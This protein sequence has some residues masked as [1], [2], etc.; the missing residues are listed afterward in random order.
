M[1]LIKTLSVG[2]LVTTFLAGPWLGWTAEAKEKKASAKTKP[3]PLETCLVSGEKL[4]GSMG[5]P[6][7]FAYEGREIKMCCKDCKKDFDKTPAKFVAKF[8][9]AWKKVKAYP[10]ET[11][12]VSGDK[13]GDKDYAFV[14]KNQEIRL[15][16]KDCLKEFNKD[17][18]KYLK[19]IEV[20]AAKA[21]K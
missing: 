3:Y 1:K 13:L 20:A 21:E 15:C 2:V 9:A 11:C 5:E 14:Q 8:D 4:G 12:V 19:Q 16:C 10:L 18:A 7:V 6:Y 17:T